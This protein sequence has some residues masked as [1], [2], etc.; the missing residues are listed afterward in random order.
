MGQSIKP[1]DFEMS[2]SEESTISV[3]GEFKSHTSPTTTI[4]PHTAF[5]MFAF[6]CAAISLSFF[7]VTLLKPSEAKSFYTTPV[8]HAAASYLQFPLASSVNFPWIV[9]KASFPWKSFK[10]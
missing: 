8:T 2:C 5:K 4:T 3:L 10:H 9:Y 1:S 6:N 7:F